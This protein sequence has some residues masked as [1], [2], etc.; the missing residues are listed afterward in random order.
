MAK[1]RHFLLLMGAV[2]ALPTS[3]LAGPDLLSLPLEDLLKIEISSASRK[4]QLVQDVAAAVFV[5]SREEIARSG[6]RSIPDALRLAPGVEVARVGNNS[7]AVS[8]RGFNGRFANKLLVLKDGRAVYSP[9]YGGVLWEAEDAVLSDIERIEVIR[10]PSA[11]MWGANAV[12]GVINIISRHAAQTQGT[13]V[14]V[15][16]ATDAPGS[17]TLRHGFP[18]GDGF[19]RLS[20][21]GFEQS[22]SRTGAGELGNDSWTSGRLGLRGDWPAQDGGHWMLV[23]EVYRSRSGNRLDQSGL[24]AAGGLQDIDQHTSGGHVLLRRE[25][26]QA[27]GGQLDWQVAIE[28]TA[29]NLQTFVHEDRQ[30]LS[31]EVQ[32]RTLLGFHDLLW[33]AAY[34]YSRD[35]LALPASAI[36]EGT[37]FG[38][39]QRTSQTA[40]V[41]VHDDYALIPAQLHLS[42]GVR[43][44]Y[45]RWSGTQAQPDIRLAWTPDARTTWWTSLARAARTPSRLE[46]DGLYALGETPAT[47]SS[48]AIRLLRLPPAQHALQAE[49]VTALE[50]GFRRQVTAQW[51]VDASVFVSDYANLVSATTGAPEWLS[52]TLVRVPLSSNNAASARTHGF[53]VAAVW[54]VSPQWRLQPHYT[55]LYLNSPRLSDPAAAAMQDQWAGRVARHRASLRSSWTLNEG[56]QLDLW[57]KYTSRLSNP[58]VPGYTT[59]DLRYAVRIGRHGEIALVG[60]NLLDRRHPEFVSDYLPIQQTE[61]GRSLQL[62]GVWHF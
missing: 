59:L 51:S 29:L 56:A 24:G 47:P 4:V 50:A 27:D 31:G 45:D 19:G 55:R 25:Q 52:P 7:W 3:A 54:Q 10:G 23:S 16:T 36:P 49:R 40:S 6:A 33:G 17:V 58:Q 43:L 32:R 2:A 61:I 11:A 42:G 30:T 13:E 46:M 21:K 35:Q 57:L 20:L 9:L 1:T 5:I 15:A 37:T 53:E 62:K 34:R 18:L 22:P 60:Q 14:H 38:A 44:S 48:P 41:F 39:V 8:I 26:P 28:S 12:N